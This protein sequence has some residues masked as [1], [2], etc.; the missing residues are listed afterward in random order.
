MNVKAKYRTRQREELLSY[1]ETVPG[2]HLTVSDICAALAQSGSGMGQTTV[3]RQLESLLEEGLVNKY[4]L[5]Q[6]SPACYEYIPLDS[7]VCTQCFHCKCVRCG[8]LYH[9]HCQELESIAHHLKEE[10]HFYMDPRRTVFYGLCE[11]CQ[12]E[13]KRASS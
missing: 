10:H 3:Y 1:L 4:S 5:D 2:V 9:L 6:K 8:Q 11:E 12:E 7:H 13:E